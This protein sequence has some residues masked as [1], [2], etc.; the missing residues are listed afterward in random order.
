M[1]RTSK[2]LKLCKSDLTYES[3]KYDLEV[4]AQRFNGNFTAMA[5]ETGLGLYQI[6]RYYKKFPEF[7]QIVDDAREAFY[8]TALAKL[9]ELV[10]EGN[11]A[12]INLFF[13]RSPWAKAQ[14]WGDRIETDSTV[15]LSDTEKAQ[16]AKE[17]LGI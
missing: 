4:A 8:N 13:S 15:K 12:A 11:M 16:K 1:G 3:R 14:G 17:I 6:Q 2:S 9:S 7:K 5:K 10:E